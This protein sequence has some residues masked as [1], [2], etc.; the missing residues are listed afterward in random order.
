MRATQADASRQLAGLIRSRVQY[1][2]QHYRTLDV[3]AAL[4]GIMALLASLASA[5]KPSQVRHGGSR[6]APD[7]DAWQEQLL[8][9]FQLLMQTVGALAD[10]GPAACSPCL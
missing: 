2:M 4:E 9:A 7:A 5:G 10:P 1:C 3:R 8:L 6:G